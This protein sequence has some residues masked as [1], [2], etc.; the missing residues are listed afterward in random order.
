M[1]E[2]KDTPIVLKTKGINE[3]VIGE[4]GKLRVVKSGETEV[5]SVATTA[6]DNTPVKWV[7]IAT[8]YLKEAKKMQPAQVYDK[9]GEWKSKNTDK[10]VNKYGIGHQYVYGNAVSAKPTKKDLLEGTI[11]YF[12]PFIDVPSLENGCYIASVDTPKI[13]SAYFAKSKDEFKYPGETGKSNIYTYKNTIRLYILGH[14]LPNYTVDYHN[15]ALFEIEIWDTDGN[16]ITEDEKPLRYF[17][18]TN[19]GTFSVNTLTEI[20]IVI[21]EKWREKSKH[22][23]KTVKT[24]YAKIKTTLYYNEDTSTEEKLSEEE[25]GRNINHHKN[26]TNRNPL[27]RSINKFESVA[28]NLET[29]AVTYT[30]EDEKVSNS[31][32]YKVLFGLFSINAGRDVGYGM[33]HAAKYTTKDVGTYDT[34]KGTVVENQEVSFQVKYDTMDVVLDKYEAQKNNMF[35]VVGDV[36]YS[37]RSNEPCK[38]SKLLI[39]HKSRAEPFVLFDEDSTSTAPIDH[40]DL[41]FGI[42]AGDKKETIKI[43]AVGLAIQNYQDKGLKKPRCFG[44]TTSKR[45]KKGRLVNKKEK[46]RDQEEFKHNTIEDV[47][48]MEKAYV[49]YP[50]ALNTTTNTNSE[51]TGDE[52]LDIQSQDIDYTHTKNGIKLEVGYLYNKNYDN[53]VLNFLAYDTAYLKSNQFIEALRNIWVVRYLVKIAKGEP[54]HQSYFVPIGTCRYPNQLARIAVYPDMKWVINFHYN[55][56]EPLYYNQ[57]PTEME[58]QSHSGDRDMSGNIKRKREAA[59]AKHIS[60]AYQNQKSEFGLYVECEVDGSSKI[61]LGKDFAEKFRKMISPLTWMVDRL[62]SD[63]G[64]SNAKKEEEKLKLSGKKGLM[65]RLNKLPMSF[66]LKAPNIGVGL[67]IGY[68]ETQCHEVGYELEGRILMNPIIGANVTL[69]VLALGSKFK[70]WGA[71]ID[72]L[73]I[74]AFLLEFC[75]GG[76]IEAEYVIEVK[77][78][79]EI[80]LVGTGSKDGSNKPAEL[81]Y[82]FANKKYAGNI[83]LQGRLR[84]EITFKFGIKLKAVVMDAKGIV[85]EDKDKKME[86]IAGVGIE[87]GAHSEVSLTLGKNFGEQDNFTSDFYFSGVTVFIKFQGGRKKKKKP[88]PYE[89]IPDLE[90]SFDVLKNKGEYK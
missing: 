4:E 43:T 65:A 17:Q 15:F 16:K 20:N 57:T 75:S 18:K 89:I 40:T 25:K 86:E 9:W 70:P 41:V 8:E 74:A 88:S 45:L 64:V 61:K 44:I 49:L 58:Y 30:E 46:H 60:T 55:I 26:P 32:E 22:K 39:E 10:P 85:P 68:G 31:L 12:E 69:D 23:E 56:K 54:I 1:A 27:M 52:T 5:L 38:Y 59:T 87:L 28:P 76:K 24:Y 37:A 34:T 71:I 2:K 21:D 3:V 73:D 13:L 66:E 47:F 19:P 14:M 48:T 29:V 79:A 67:G 33:R 77:F 80:S 6:S 36:E 90:K 35:V 63:L 42:V 81:T 72:A 7:W 78:T 82:N 62:D 53:R 11:Y 83:A 51:T 84:G 50:D